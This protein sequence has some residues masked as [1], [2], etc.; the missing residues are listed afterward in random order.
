L[1]IKMRKIAELAN[2]GKITI[3]TVSE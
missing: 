1:A 3:P 2:D